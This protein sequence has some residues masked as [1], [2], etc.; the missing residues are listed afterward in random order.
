[1]KGSSLYLRTSLF[2][3]ESSSVLILRSILDFRL[4]TGGLGSINRFTPT[5][6][7]RSTTTLGV[8]LGGHGPNYGSR[9]FSILLLALSLCVCVWTSRRTFVTMNYLRSSLLPFDQSLPYTHTHTR[10]TILTMCVPTPTGS[11]LPN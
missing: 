6:G 5:T 1:M 11:V 8:C 7:R 10:S 9:R 3:L 2:S 4:K